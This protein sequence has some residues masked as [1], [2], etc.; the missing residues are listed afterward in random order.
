M[1]I[2]SCNALTNR[3]IDSAIATGATRSADIYAACGVRAQCGGCVPTVLCL[4]RQA[5]SASH[6][7]AP[8]QPAHAAAAA[9]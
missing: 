8:Q 5:M 4:L 7:A 2:C 9:C 6:L 3:D 1:Y